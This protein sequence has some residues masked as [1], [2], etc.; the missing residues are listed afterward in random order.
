MDEHTPTTLAASGRVCLVTFRKLPFLPFCHGAH[1]VTNATAVQTPVRE[2]KQAR[3][4][5]HAQ[6]RSP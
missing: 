4:V 2:V 3:W 1:P 5:V 6:P